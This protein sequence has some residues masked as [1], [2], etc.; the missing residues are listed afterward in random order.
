MKPTNIFV[1][2]F[3][4]V[5]FLVLASFV[6]TRQTGPDGPKQPQT[7]EQLG[8]RLFNDVILSVDRT[9]SCASCHKAAFAFADNMARSP[10]VNGNITDRNTPSVMYLSQHK[11]FFWDGRAKTYEEQA[12]GPIASPKEMG[13]PLPEAEKRLQESPFYQQAFRQVYQAGPSLALMARALADFQRSLAPHNSPYDR[14]VAGDIDALSP[15][16]VRGMELFIYDANCVFCHK[17]PYFD[18]DAY[19]NIGLFDGK[20]LNDVGRFGI[21]RDSADLGGFATPPLRNIALT[22]P[23]MHDGSM[24]TLREVLDYYN[25]PDKVV[26]NSRNRHKEMKP[27]NLTKQKISDLEAFLNSLTDDSFARSKPR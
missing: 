14:Y 8:E 23:Y 20:K 24:N 10:G 13:L 15:A 18:N 3:V 4:S 19:F 2:S 27:L 7:S 22:A 9:L 26:K 25:E 12:L 6:S 17:E 21:S 5:C 16:A 1:L 11:H